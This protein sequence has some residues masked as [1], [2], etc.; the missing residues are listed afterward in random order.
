MA[1][2]RGRWALPSDVDIATQGYADFVDF[3]LGYRVVGLQPTS[4]SVPID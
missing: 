3:A 1:M 2:S 4:G